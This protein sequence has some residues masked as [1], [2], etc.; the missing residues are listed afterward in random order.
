MLIDQIEELNSGSLSGEPE[1]IMM[2]CLAGRGRT[3]TAIAIVNA[4]IA[5]KAQL[6][7]K[8]AIDNL[9][10]SVFSIVRRLREQR[11]TAVQT[12]SQYVFIYQLLARWMELMQ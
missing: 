4:M 3:G 1:S 9:Q 2:H 6:R 10:L 5:L 11:A 12:R 8:V 7:Q